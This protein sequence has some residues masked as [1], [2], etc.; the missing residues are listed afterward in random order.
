MENNS[1]RMGF[2]LIA[3]SVV[4]FV[5][6]AVNGLLKSTVGGFFNGFNNMQTGVIDDVDNAFN[7]KV[8]H[9][10]YANNAAGT[11][12]FNTDYKSAVGLD[13][14]NL[15]NWAKNTPMSNSTFKVASSADGSFNVTGKGTAGYEVLSKSF[16]ANVG[17]KIR[18]TVHYTNR[19]AFDLFAGYGLQFVVSNVYTDNAASTPT[20]KIVLSNEITMPKEYQLDYTA[21]TNNVWMQ[22]N[23]GGVSDSSVV[24]FDVKVEVENLTNPVKYVYIGTYSDHTATDSTNPSD[25]TWRVMQSDDVK[26]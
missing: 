21:T 4:A 26:D 14:L 12:D 2:A 23:L 7:Q 1:D 10:A 11:L 19:R 17:D 22:L 13:V 15:T 16:P 25:Y 9:T 5:L 20:S 24:D 18:F 3:L 6:L 8:K